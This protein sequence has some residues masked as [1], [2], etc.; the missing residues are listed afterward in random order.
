MNVSLFKKAQDKFRAEKL[1][2][3]RQNHAKL[4]EAQNEFAVLR[5]FTDAEA[6]FTE[7]VQTLREAPEVPGTLKALFAE[8]LI[9]L[10]ETKKLALDRTVPLAVRR[11]ATAKLAAEFAMTSTTMKTTLGLK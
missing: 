11:D 4:T 9:R 6:Q 1:A 2:Q 5:A 7:A 10:R 3:A 8:A